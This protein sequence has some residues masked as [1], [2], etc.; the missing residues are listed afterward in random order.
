M[1]S[2]SKELSVFLIS[3]VLIS[4]LL[5]S[6]SEHFSPVY[7]NEKFRIEKLLRSA[8]T[9][10]AISVGDSHS[11]GL[12]FRAMNIRGFP[13]WKGGSDLF[14]VCYFLNAVTPRLTRLRIVF[15]DISP[16]VFARDNGSYAAFQ[17]IRQT[18]YYMTP[19]VRSWRLING[20]LKNFVRG[21]LSP[22]LR[23]DHW[24]GV[25]KFLAA[26]LFHS[27]VHQDKPVDEFGY[28]R[29]KPTVEARSATKTAYQ[30]FEP[31]LA[32]T[33]GNTDVEK[34]SY[35]ELASTLKMLRQKK[36]R[37]I[38]FTTPFPEMVAKYL[39]TKRGTELQRTR[40]YAQRLQ[41][42]CDVEYYDLL[43]DESFST[44]YDYFIDENHLNQVGAEVFSRKLAG[45]ISKQEK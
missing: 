30:R 37:V 23:A 2:V 12:D 33:W 31:V 36:I 41:R 9:I 35:H 27:K 45:L 28:V 20:D 42:E 13:L 21:K 6:A 44:R 32:Y 14:E 25:A 4:A 38:L 15:L 39:L 5:Y 22:I 24:S 10:E 17:P 26:S 8:G 3:L 40:Q 43:Q 18:Y 7:P 1:K 11:L 16:M 29:Q 19:T 34:A